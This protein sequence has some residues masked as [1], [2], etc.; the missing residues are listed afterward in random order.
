VEPSTTAAKRL[1]VRTKFHNWLAAFQFMNL[2]IHHFISIHSRL[3][4]LSVLCR[5]FLL[6]PPPDLM[7]TVEADRVPDKTSTHNS[8]LPNQQNLSAHS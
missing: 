6:T 1:G 4:H 7:L 2:F 5:K 8:S 3:S